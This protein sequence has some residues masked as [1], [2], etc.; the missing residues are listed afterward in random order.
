MLLNAI[1]LPSFLRVHLIQDPDHPLA[2]KNVLAAYLKRRVF[3]GRWAMGR[4]PLIT[5]MLNGIRCNQEVLINICTI[6]V[7]LRKNSFTF[8]SSSSS[9]SL[10]PDSVIVP[11]EDKLLLA[12]MIRLRT[13]SL[14][15]MSFV[16]SEMTHNSKR[17]H[18]IAVTLQ[19]GRTSLS[20][21]KV[22]SICIDWIRISIL[23]KSLATCCQF[24]SVLGR[25]ALT[26]LKMKTWIPASAKKWL[27]RSKHR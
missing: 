22:A 24:A 7:K 21:Y 19:L 15:C 27:F 23:L 2:G 10:H 5:E 17:K 4:Y 3:R 11:L 9:H 18:F 14:I 1:F 13:V 25:P 12:R 26:Q 8:F 6:C 20:V 16:S